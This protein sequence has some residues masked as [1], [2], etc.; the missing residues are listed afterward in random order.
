MNI[1]EMLFGKKNKI[2]LE[3]LEDKIKQKL[4]TLTK[5]DSGK[6]KISDMDLGHLLMYYYFISKDIDYPE[7]FKKSMNLGIRSIADINDIIKEKLCAFTQEDYSKKDRL[8]AKGIVIIIN[9]FKKASELALV[10]EL[11]GQFPDTYSGLNIDRNVTIQLQ[12]A[13][14]YKK[15]VERELSK[16]ER[17]FFS[18]VYYIDTKKNFLD[19]K[20]REQL[21]YFNNLAI[22]VSE[23]MGKKPKKLIQEYYDFSRKA[24]ELL[25]KYNSVLGITLNKENKD[26]IG[27]EF[28]E[29]K[30]S[31]DEIKKN[32]SSRNP[33]Y[34]I[35][36]F[37]IPKIEKN[38]K[39]DIVNY[40]MKVNSGNL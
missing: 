29:I 15:K 2:D 18:A 8:N 36:L 26:R 6:Q 10:Q 23:E 34:A 7:I 22:T 38:I 28:I 17:L 33:K 4:D 3:K 19:E 32:F 9:K 25:I 12:K 14:K 21:N 5:D 30:K 40:L 35:N 11:I 20:Y 27:K 13:A 39:D 31:Y 1:K 16:I 24:E 37:V